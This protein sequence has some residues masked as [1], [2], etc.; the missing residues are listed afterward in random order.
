[1]NKSNHTSK[2]HLKHGKDMPNTASTTPK[3]ANTN[4]V[5]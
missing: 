3:L 1:M 2:L 4:I 5:P